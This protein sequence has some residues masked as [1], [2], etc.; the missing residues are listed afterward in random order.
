MCLQSSGLD[1]FAGERDEKKIQGAC[2]ASYYL[3]A[4]NIAWHQT[5]SKPNRKPNSQV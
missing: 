4:V 1:E 5:I 3:G 2:G